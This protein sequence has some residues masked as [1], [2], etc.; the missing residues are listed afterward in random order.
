MGPNPGS[1]NEQELVSLRDLS[2]MTGLSSEFLK[3][4]LNFGDNDSITLEEL[5]VKML[6][7]LDDSLA[8]E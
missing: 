7:L 2:E 4:E 6:S 3:G 5:R 1:G 8:Q